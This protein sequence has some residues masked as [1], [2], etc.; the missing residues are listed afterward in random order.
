MLADAVGVGRSGLRVVDREAPAEAVCVPERLGVPV[1]V[2]ETEDVPVS[3]AVSVVVAVN[4][5]VRV[6]V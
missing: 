6:P 3:D 5:P 4:V 2:V 1:A